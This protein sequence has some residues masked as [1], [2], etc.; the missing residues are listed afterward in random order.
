MS[1]ATIDRY[2]Q[3]HKAAAYPAAGLSGT[4]PSQI[5]R[6]SISTRTPMDDPITTPGFL[7]LDTVAHCGHSLKGDF[8]T[9]L[10]WWTG[11]EM[12]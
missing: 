1:A 4:R 10:V 7:E 5:L 2:L 6:A 3:A 8:G 11:V 9:F 12:L